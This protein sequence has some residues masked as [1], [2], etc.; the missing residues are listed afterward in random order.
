MVKVVIKDEVGLHAR[1][2]T[3]LSM[4]AKKYESNIVI[5]KDGRA[6][7]AKSPMMVMSLGVGYMEEIVLEANGPDAVKAESDL[8]GLLN[9]FA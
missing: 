2:A 8:A 3:V 7:N 1:P 5:S 6:V 4:E 9:S